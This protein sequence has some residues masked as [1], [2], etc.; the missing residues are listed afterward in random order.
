MSDYAISAGRRVLDEKR[1]SLVLDVIK[2]CVCKKIQIKLKKST[3][4][5][6][7][8]SDGERQCMD[9]NGYFIRILGQQ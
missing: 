8:D 7:N 4:K 5:Q 1:T 3:R 9:G 6:E 2:I